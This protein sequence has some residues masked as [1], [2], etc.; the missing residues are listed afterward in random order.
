MNHDRANY[1]PTFYGRDCMDPHLYRMVI[2]S[3]IGTER[4][5]WMIVK[6]VQRG[7]QP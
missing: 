2:S 3:Q 4:A 6:A 1:I 7:C 5:A